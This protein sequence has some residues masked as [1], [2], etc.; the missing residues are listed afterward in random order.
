[1]EEINLIKGIK[2]YEDSVYEAYRQLDLNYRYKKGKSRFTDMSL[3]DNLAYIKHDIQ[4]S[5]E[6]L[7]IYEETKEIFPGP[8]IAA[9]LI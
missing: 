7:S 8:E 6:G 3:E 5:N 4:N 1:M 2:A 9:H